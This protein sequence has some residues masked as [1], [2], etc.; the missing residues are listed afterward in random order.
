MTRWVSS[1]NYDTAGDF[2]DAVM[3]MAD[4]HDEECQAADDA[5]SEREDDDD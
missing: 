2:W 3:A 4:E 1:A 5:W